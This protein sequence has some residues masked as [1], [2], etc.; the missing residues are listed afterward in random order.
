MLTDGSV[1]R[2]KKSKKPIYKRHW[3]IVL[4]VIIILGGISSAFGDD[5]DNEETISDSVKTQSESI[6]TE[7]ESVESE[8]DSI[9][10]S[11][12][13]KNI[14]ELVA[15]ENSPYGQEYTLN[16]ETQ[17]VYVV[18]AGTY[19]VTNVGKYMSQVN[20]Y[21]FDTQKQGEWDEPV[22]GNV[23]MVDVN[24]TET[25]EVFENSYIEIHTPTHITLELQ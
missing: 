3:F 9:D 22:D 24:S 5:K 4:V 8:K 15:G 10:N 2:E 14:I 17:I 21:S 20:C 25:F 18:P 1:M 23:V 19:L 13:T 11:D 16:E 7:S 6:L 12:K